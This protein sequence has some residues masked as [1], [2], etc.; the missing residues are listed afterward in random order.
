MLGQEFKPNQST[1]L[2][3]CSFLPF[4]CRILTFD[5]LPLYYVFMICCQ[6]K[7]S[8]HCVMFLHST[9]DNSSH[10]STQIFK[11][12]S[13]TTEI[14]HTMPYYYWHIFMLQATTNSKTPHNGKMCK[15]KWNCLNGNFKRIYDYHK[16]NGNNTSY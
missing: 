1:K 6:H 10:Y 12:H 8:H 13:I 3:C 11:L 15:D 2:S 16:G 14:I 4:V 5:Q 9:I 7:F